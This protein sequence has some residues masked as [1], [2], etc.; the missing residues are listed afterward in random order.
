LV[1][2]LMQ[3]PCGLPTQQALISFGFSRVFP[4]FS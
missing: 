3:A 2:S 4:V 1:V